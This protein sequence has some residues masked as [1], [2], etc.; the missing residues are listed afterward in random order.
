MEKMESVDYKEPYS[1]KVGKFLL[2]RDF[3]LSSCTGSANYSLV[4]GRVIGILRKDP[5]AKP[6][7]YLLGLLTREP[8]R[9]FIGTIWFE[10]RGASETRW[11]LEVYG[12]KHVELLKQLGEEMASTFNTHI[13]IRLVTE[14]PKLET[15]Y[16]DDFH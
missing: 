4:E 9:A 2:L 14:Q 8:L 5:E 16:E 10:G 7:K 6:Q 13:D 12:R 15:T 1:I 3:V 11:V